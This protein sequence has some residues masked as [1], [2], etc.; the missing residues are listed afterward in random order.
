L[1]KRS[2]KHLQI[3]RFTE[4]IRVNSVAPEIGG[5]GTRGGIVTALDPSPLTCRW[6]SL[7]FFDESHQA[8]W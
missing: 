4:P 1:K 6:H 5:T 7:A 3:A 2:K 8:S